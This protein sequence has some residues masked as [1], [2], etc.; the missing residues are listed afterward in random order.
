MWIFGIP[1]IHLTFP[2]KIDATH[3][4]LLSGDSL[5]AESLL[6]FLTDLM[7]METAIRSGRED[8]VHDLLAQMSETEAVEQL[9]VTY[10]LGKHSPDD[11][12]LF[13]GATPVLHAARRGE[14]AVF[15]VIVRVMRERMDSHEV[16]C[17]IDCKLNTCFGTG[18]NF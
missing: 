6:F 9:T 15:S 3:V 14:P 7:T 11:D 1:S 16:S 18:R 10:G 2:V 8:V 13:E 5:M 17:A 4:L 12:G